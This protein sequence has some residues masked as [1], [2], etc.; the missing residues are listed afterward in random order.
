[1]IIVL[2]GLLAVAGTLAVVA[3]AHHAN[4]R[5]IAGLKT[6]TVIT[7]KDT[8]AARTSL[9]VAEKDGLLTHTKIPAESV[10]QGIC[11]PPLV[12]RTELIFDSTRAAG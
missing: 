5:A 8:I 7:A 9:G 12:C 11:A 2:A 4:E 1:M 3:Y 10:R 6:V